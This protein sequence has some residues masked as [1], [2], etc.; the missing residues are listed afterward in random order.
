MKIIHTSDWHLG[1]NFYGYD[2]RDEHSHMVEQLRALV[3][4][5]QP[6]V[7]VIAG[8]VYDVGSPNTMA[9]KDFAKYLVSLCKACPDMTIVCIAGNHDSA[10][11]HEVFQEPWEAFGVY[12][13]GKV[14]MDDIRANIIKVKDNGYVVAVPYTNERFL[15]DDFYQKLSAAVVQECGDDGLPVVYVGHASIMDLDYD[16]H[17]TADESKY[18]GNI[19]CTSVER[20]GD[21]YDYI[22]LGHI[23][24]AQT[25]YNDRARYC[26]SPIPVSFDEVK[27]G[28]DHGFTVVQIAARGDVPQIST[29]PV[30]CVCPL[31]NIPSMGFAS[32]KDAMAELKNFPAGLEAYIRLNIEVEEQESLPYDR[33]AQISNALFGKLGKYCLINVMRKSSVAAGKSEGV[34]MELEELQNEDPLTLV[35]RYFASEGMEFTEDF[36]DMFNEAVAAV[37]SVRDEN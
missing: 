29:V 2:R 7:L 23:H 22:A 6:D 19:E 12:T 21:V 4:Q 5:Q 16:G 18:V 34:P 11:R 27:P 9:Q 24:K 36:E 31:V 10:S 35:K 25:F 14:N 3:E 32:W 26:G 28:Y 13:I 17:K 1:Q 20:I 37:N 8:D 15:D 33:E 30:K